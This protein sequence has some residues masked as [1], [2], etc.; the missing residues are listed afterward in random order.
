MNVELPG[1]GY[2]RAGV[3]AEAD[4]RS[5][6]NNSEHKFTWRCPGAQMSGPTPSSWW[7]LASLGLDRIPICLRPSGTKLLRRAACISRLSAACDTS[8]SDSRTSKQ[9]LTP[10]IFGG[11]FRPRLPQRK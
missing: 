9:H 4:F 6:L 2:Q 10:L 8:W 5:W 7:T 3:F 1:S 11:F